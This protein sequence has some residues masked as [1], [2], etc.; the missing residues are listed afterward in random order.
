MIHATPQRAGG[1]FSPYRMLVAYYFKKEL[2]APMLSI[3]N[4]NMI[5]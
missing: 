5:L 4:Q 1:K 3:K 2:P